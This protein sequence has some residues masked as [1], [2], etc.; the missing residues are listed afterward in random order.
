MTGDDMAG[1][2]QESL[3]RLHSLDWEDIGQRLLVY[4]RYW[5]KTH[6]FWNQETPL[7]EQKVPED[8]AKEAIGAFWEGTRQLNP[9]YPVITQLKGAVRSILWNLHAKK[10]SKVTRIEGPEF[11]DERFDE[12]PSPDDALES[13]DYERAIFEALFEHPRVARSNELRRLV[14]SFQDGAVSVDDAVTATGIQAKRIY[15]LRRE[16]KEIT[17]EVIVTINSIRT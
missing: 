10:E 14:K 1:L 3:K 8:I 12:N 15:Q 17:S 9:K 13:S 11:F 2:D 16:L 6:Y 4:A 7:P 5:A